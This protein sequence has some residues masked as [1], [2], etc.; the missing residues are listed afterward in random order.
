MILKY[1]IIVFISQIIFV[2]C[3]TWNV[4][5]ISKN[6][7]TAAVVSG[8]LVQVVW[9]IN[10]AIGSNFTLKFLENYDFQYIPV[11]LLS[12]TGGAI[13]TYLS[14]KIKRNPNG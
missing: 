14:L 4:K 6:D 1:S 5:S 8:I 3:R 11:V 10:I 12:L 7:V 2:A 13:G 9:L